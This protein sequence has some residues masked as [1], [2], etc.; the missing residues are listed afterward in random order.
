MGRGRGYQA[1]FLGPT[2]PAVPLPSFAESLRDHVLERASFSD[3]GGGRHIYRHYHNHTI[4]M[5]KSRRTALFAA[6]NVDRSTLQKTDRTAGWRID[7]AVGAENQLD[8]DYYRANA[9]DRGHLAPDAA[10]GWG[11]SAEDRVA[12][13]NDTYY[14]TNA[15]LQHE[16]F[17]RDEWKDLEAA[18][19]SWRPAT[20]DRLTEITGPVFGAG[21]HTVRPEGREALPPS[22]SAS[23][24]YWST[25]EPV[26]DWKCAVL[27]CTRM[28]HPRRT[29]PG[30]LNTSAFRCRCPTSNN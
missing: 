15:A 25:S 2:L 10:A 13:T 5:S 11:A 19:R 30:S 27:P 3:D 28:T 7:A 14:Y 4:V 8:G 16:N 18:A 1:G 26:L 24:R 21:G 12:A 9:W 20:T 22:P 23:S 17:N 6:L 29:G